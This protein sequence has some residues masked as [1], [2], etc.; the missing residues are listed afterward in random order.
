MIRSHGRFDAG[1]MDEGALPGLRSKLL[2]RRSFLIGSAV[3][4][5]ALGLAGCASSDD[6]LRAEAAKLR[7]GPRLDR[8]Q[9]LARLDAARKD[10]RF[11]EPVATL[12][13]KKAPEASTDD[14]LQA[15]V[16]AIELLSKAGKA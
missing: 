12:F 9:L 16:D 11:E 3:G 7:Q 1:A 14:E 15:L 6:L 10:P 5:G 2:N 8:A 13:Q 4:L